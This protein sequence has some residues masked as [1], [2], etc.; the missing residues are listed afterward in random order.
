MSAANDASCSTR[1]KDGALEGSRAA[2]P[3][4]TCACT[5][6]ASLGFAA[7]TFVKGEGLSQRARRERLGLSQLSLPL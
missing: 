1:R 3:T 6:Q 4:D 7:E 2:G 5:G